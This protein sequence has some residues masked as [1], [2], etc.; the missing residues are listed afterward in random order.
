MKIE[1]QWGEGWARTSLDNKV[2]NRFKYSQNALF[3]DIV[4]K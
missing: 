3:R 2:S 1:G 4:F